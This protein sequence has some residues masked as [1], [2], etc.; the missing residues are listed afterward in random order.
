M[1]KIELK[2]TKI[3]LKLVKIELKLIKIELK[4]IEVELKLTQK[5]TRQVLDLLPELSVKLLHLLT[6]LLNILSQRLDSSSRQVLKRLR[7]SVE[8]FFKLFLRLRSSLDQSRCRLRSISNHLPNQLLNALE[9]L[10]DLGKNFLVE[11][12]HEV[13]IELREEVLND[14]ELLAE[15]VHKIFEILRDGF[16]ERCDVSVE[17]L[18]VWIVLDLFDAFL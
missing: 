16:D 10:S 2:L 1:I 3:E 6:N 11:A 5:L 12:R 17:L 7:N 8:I 18:N 13:L 4:V 9:K 14:R 15:S